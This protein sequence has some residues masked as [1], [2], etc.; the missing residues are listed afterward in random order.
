MFRQQVSCENRLLVK[1]GKDYD[2]ND[3]ELFTIPADEKELDLKQYLYESILLS[4]PIQRIH[5]DDNKGEIT[6]DREM[7]NKLKEH[8]V[9]EERG[10][11]D[12]R[13]E[14]LKKL[15]NKN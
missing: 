10:E 6:C 13:W 5:P 3:P 15:M 1:F 14:E 7:L 2:V 8:L 12:P 9:D 4:L 11:T